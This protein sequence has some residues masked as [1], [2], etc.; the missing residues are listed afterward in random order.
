M[1]TQNARKS[2]LLIEDDLGV[3][4][5][6][7]ILLEDAGYRVF[8]AADAVE[9]ATIWQQQLGQFDVVVTDVLLPGLSGPEV[10]AEFRR[11]RPDLQVIFMSGGVPASAHSRERSSAEFLAKPFIPQALVDAIER[12]A[13]RGLELATPVGA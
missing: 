2:I 3:R 4:S 6:L 13:G 9:A 8:E 12:A 5:I 7:V 10:I 11:D 1:H